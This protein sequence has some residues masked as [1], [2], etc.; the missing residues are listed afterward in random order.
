MEQI[1]YE[2]SILQKCVKF[3][4]LSWA[5]K[6][7]G[8]S[9]P[10]ISR[11]L[12]KI[13]DR[14]GFPLLDRTSKRSSAWLPEAIKLT[15]LF[16]LQ[17][18]NFEINL[19]TLRKTEAPTSLR[20]GLL[21]GMIPSVADL[22]QKINKEYNIRLIEVHDFDLTE[23]ENKFYNGEVDILFTSQEPGRRKF[24]NQLVLG[25]QSL[26]LHNKGS[27]LKVMSPFEFSTQH[28]QERK[29]KTITK[30]ASLPS[31]RLPN[32]RS[33]QPKPQK[34]LISNSLE[35]RKLWIQKTKAEGHLPSPIQKRTLQTAVP[36]IAIGADHPWMPRL[37]ETLAR[38]GR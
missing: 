38:V 14:V 19:Q 16:A 24:N 30:D 9:Q 18:R 6:H 28:Q 25:Y 2:L 36:V 33:P 27:T 31:Q 8:M 10:Q 1:V 26:D 7:V 15:E 34:I 29:F 13:E 20:L 21:E 23:H 4:N 22:L 12:R 37:F 11:I 5:A 3:K 17:I 35:W 32:K